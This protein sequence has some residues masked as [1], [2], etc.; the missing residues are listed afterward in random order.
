MSYYFR[1]K[2][3]RYRIREVNDVQLA[4]KQLRDKLDE[5]DKKWNRKLDFSIKKTERF[6]RE[7][8]IETSDA[9]DGNTRRDVELQ[10]L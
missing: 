7:V 6:C 9:E 8:G 5:F 10:H 3:K 4:T 1:S 2:E